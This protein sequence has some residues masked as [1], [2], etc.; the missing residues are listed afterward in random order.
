MTRYARRQ[1]TR[2]LAKYDTVSID[3]ELE[4]EMSVSMVQ[5]R[6]TYALLDRL[7]EQEE[8][9]TARVTRFPYWAEIWPAAVGLSRWFVQHA[10]ESTSVDIRE[11]GC[12]LGL[13]GVALARSG[14]RVEATDYVEDA[15]VLAAHNARSN[16]VAEYR[17]RVA[18]LDWSHPV[19]EVCD[20]LVASDVAYEKTLHPYLL[21]T[22]RQLLRPGGRLYLSD[23]RRP[24]AQPL[25]E[26]LRDLGYEH[27]R[28]TVDVEWQSLT[29]QI[30]IHRLRKPE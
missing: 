11:L 6:D 20:C 19:G 3:V 4:P 21:R 1:T 18:Y 8:A 25:F 12:G 14:W 16:G 24:A 13:V 7:I 5:T 30:D 28:H 23:P 9:G 29:H 26:A 17:H 22:L 27:E 15:L 10:P 2:T